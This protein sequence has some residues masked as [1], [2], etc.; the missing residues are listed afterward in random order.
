[1]MVY[2]IIYNTLDSIE[3]DSDNYCK[4]PAFH[5]GQLRS[6]CGGRMDSSKLLAI[7]KGHGCPVRA[8]AKKVVSRSMALPFKKEVQLGLTLH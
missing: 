6:V 1:M 5:Q 8:L 3:Y 7:Q 4:R 2:V